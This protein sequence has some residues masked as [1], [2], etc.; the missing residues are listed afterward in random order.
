M[1]TTGSETLFQWLIESYF[2]EFNSISRLIR[3][4]RAYNIT[5][6]NRESI[7]LLPSIC[8]EI[9]ENCHPDPIL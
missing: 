7:F 9:Y 6:S 2:L 8:E 1:L 5:G 4:I 3:T